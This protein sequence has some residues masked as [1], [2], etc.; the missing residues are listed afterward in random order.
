MEIVDIYN[1]KV[2]KKMLWS[3]HRFFTIAIKKE[4]Y[5]F[6]YPSRLIMLQ[7]IKVE[8][9][10]QIWGIIVVKSQGIQTRFG[11]LVKAQSEPCCIQLAHN[12]RI[13]LAHLFLHPEFA[14][15][16]LLFFQCLFAT[17]ERGALLI[18]PRP[19]TFQFQKAQYPTFLFK[20]HLFLYY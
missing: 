12:I 14:P 17:S 19:Q 1:L 5:E 10:I 15:S 4:T 3:I 2:K 11:N 13:R 18:M 20:Y 9:H 16:N 8:G 7:Y 6:T